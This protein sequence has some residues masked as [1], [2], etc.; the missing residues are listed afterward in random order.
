MA[1]IPASLAPFFQEYD[2]QA[3]DLEVSSWTIIERT[4]QYG[5][6]AELRWLFSCYPW[7]VIR[8]WVQRWGNQALPEPHLTFWRLLLELPE[9]E[10]GDHLGKGW[11]EE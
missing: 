3:L 9:A 1:E 11:I 6:R 5:N 10:A 4:L 8:A 2:L 7:E